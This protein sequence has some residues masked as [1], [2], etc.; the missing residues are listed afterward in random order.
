MVGQRKSGS[1]NVDKIEDIF[2]REKEIREAVWE[3]K[4]GAGGH[5]GG[6]PSGHSY[7]SDPTPAQA[8]R[9]AEELPCVQLYPSKDK[10]FRP[11]AWLSVVDAVKAW[12]GHDT[13]KA[14]IYNRRYALGETSHSTCRE[15]NIEVPTYYVILREI[16][17]FA[18]ACAAQAQVIRVF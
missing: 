15:I 8:L 13:I 16:R 3:A 17:N 10:I 11:E 4:L 7:I 1:A 5:T 2:R 6:A 14:E 18:L 9:L 12:C